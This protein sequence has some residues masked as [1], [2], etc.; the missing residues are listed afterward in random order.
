MSTSAASILMQARRRAGLTQAQLGASAGVTQS[1]ISA[2]EAGKREPALATLQRLVRASGFQLDLA[3][4][5]FAP[6]SPHQRLLAS[7]RDELVARLEELGASN[8]RMFGSVARGDDTASSDVDL[9]VDL[10]AGVGLFGLARLQSESERILGVPVD[11]VPADSLKPR[12]AQ[13]VLTESRPL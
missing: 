11:I 8:V 12:M 13:R 2:Y 3:L 6:T 4:T 1:V 9:L 5:P 7:H 10:D